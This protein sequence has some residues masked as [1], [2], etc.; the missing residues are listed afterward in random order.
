LLQAHLAT[1]LS[2]RQRDVV[3]GLYFTL[4]FGVN[5]IWNAVTGFLIDV[6][7]SFTPAWVF[8]S[9][10]GAIAFVFIVLASRSTPKVPAK[11]PLPATGD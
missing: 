6:Y 5:S 11:S 9:I 8:R 2:P 1:I 3:M 4:G 7:G 10:L